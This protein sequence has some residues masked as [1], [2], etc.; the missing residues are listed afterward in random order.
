MISNF[1]LSSLKGRFPKSYAAYVETGG[2]DEWKNLCQWIEHKGYD[3]KYY[4]VALNKIEN[5]L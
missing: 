4:A 5:S 2:T 3:S 1:H